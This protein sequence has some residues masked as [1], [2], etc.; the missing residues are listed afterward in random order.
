MKS[1]KFSASQDLVHFKNFEANSL[2]DL[3]EIQLEFNWSPGI[4]KDS[5]RSLSNFEEAHS[6]GLDIDEGISLSEALGL[7]KDHK[8]IITTTR[9]HQVPKN[10]II[11]DRFRV[12]L[13]LE[14]PIRDRA[15]FEATWQSLASQYDFIDRAAKDASRFFYPSKEIISINEDG[16]EIPVKKAEPKPTPSTKPKALS[17]EQKGK[18]A[19]KTLEFLIQGAPNGEWNISLFKAAKDWFEQGYEKEEFITRA[20]NIEGWLDESSLKTIASAFSKEPLYEPR[21]LG[22]E[23]EPDVREGAAASLIVTP[24]DLSN[25]SL[26]YLSDKDAVKGEPTGLSGLDDL[27]G[28]GKRLGEVT[29]TVA[30][31]KTGKNALWHFLMHTWMKRSIPIA[32]ASRELDPA[33]EVVPDLL[34]IAFQ[35]NARLVELYADKELSY[36]EE[37]AK[38]PIAFARDQGYFNFDDLNRWVSECQE[39]LNIQY[40]WFDHLHWMLEDPEEWKTASLLSRNLKHLARKNNIHVDVIIQPSKLMDGQRLSLNSMKGGSAI[41]QNID[42]LLILERVPNQ[43]NISRL[44]LNRARSRLAS[45]GEIYLHYDPKTLSFIEGSIL[46][47]NT[48]EEEPTTHLYD[49]NRKVIS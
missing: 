19:R 34:S 4:F 46:P 26:S 27:L 11:G 40:F 2:E 49:V 17:T 22:P 18:L 21:G 28:G 31:A 8:H 43:K 9:S 36:R 12:L 30:E 38:W 6:I 15:T 42:N 39:K 33:T 41:G 48:P 24:M 25:D 29:A 45:P 44:S 1:Y 5:Y 14:E 35:E 20:E 37:M 23:Q 7:F 16:Y 13:F 47:D 3:A 32:Y 10:G